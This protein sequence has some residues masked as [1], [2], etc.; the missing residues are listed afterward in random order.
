[1]T[2]ISSGTVTLLQFDLSLAPSII[3]PE[4]ELLRVL[5]DLIVECLS[6]NYDG[7]WEFFRNQQPHMM[8][9]AQFVTLT[10][11][12][13]VFYVWIPFRIYSK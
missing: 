6:G 12:A 5:K 3:P 13:V 2:G 7:G 10:D 8:R 11:Q 9:P 1:M 4:L